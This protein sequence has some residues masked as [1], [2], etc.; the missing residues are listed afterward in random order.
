[1][2]KEAQFGSCEWNEV[3]QVTAKVTPGRTTAWFTRVL[4]L[5][6]RIIQ[7]TSSSAI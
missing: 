7:K 3:G 4:E 2:N 6:G 1:M 5:L